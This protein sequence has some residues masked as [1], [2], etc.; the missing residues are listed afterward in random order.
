VASNP[1][2][3]SGDG[4]VG[5]ELVEPGFGDAVD[6]EEVVDALERAALLAEADDGFGRDGADAGKLLKL[7][8]GGGVE[9][10]RPGGRFFLLRGG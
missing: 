3:W 10:E 9:V 4:Y 1:F 8:D 6:G 7:F 5:A 2:F